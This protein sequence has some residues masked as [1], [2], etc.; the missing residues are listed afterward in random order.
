MKIKPNKQTVYLPVK[1]EDEFPN[2]ECVMISQ[3]HD[4][5]VGY[6]AD[7]DGEIQADDEHQILSHITHWLKPKEIF[8]FTPEQLNEYTANVIRQ[9]LETAAQKAELYDESCESFGENQVSYYVDEESITNT[10]EETYKKFEV[11]ENSDIFINE[12]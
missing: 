3:T 6:P 11:W 2:G 12:Y 8:V 9:A 4:M 1:V 7:V 10:F 5:L